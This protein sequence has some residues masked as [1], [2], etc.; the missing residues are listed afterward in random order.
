MMDTTPTL[1]FIALSVSS[2]FMVF[3]PLA[4][5]IYATSRTT[6]TKQAMVEI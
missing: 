4:S 3:I 2:T 1:D 5:D 6:Q